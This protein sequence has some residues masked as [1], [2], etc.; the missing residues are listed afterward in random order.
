[1]AK[2]RRSWTVAAHSPLI[3]IDENLW[4]V[5]D[6]LGPISRRMCII[7]R[8]DGDL[9]FFHAV[10]VDEATL[11]EIRALGTPKYLV[12][13]H[14]QHAVDAHAFQEKLGLKA[15][16]PAALKAELE[17][18]FR[19]DGTL[20]DMP[21]DPT[22]ECMETPGSKHHEVSIVVKSG[23]RVSLLVS[24]A[25]QNNDPAKLRLIFRLIGFGGGPKV[26]PMYRMFFTSDKSLLKQALLG[27]A[28]MPGLVR[29]VPFHGTI[30]EH[31]ADAI[32]A[33]AAT[34]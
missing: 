13:G 31:P 34:L 8:A 4:A 11:A 16:G 5:E 12:V 3:Q 29:L 27:W 1:M 23:P 9:V 21:A 26:V 25:L 7:R 15:Y 18:R 32:R 22:I 6:T 24:D 17:K 10:P 14:H 20:A 30:V 2:D 28:A 33:A 19:L